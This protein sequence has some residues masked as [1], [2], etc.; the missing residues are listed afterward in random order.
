MSSSILKLDDL[1]M[2]QSNKDVTINGQRDGLEQGRGKAAVSI[3]G[4][5]TFTLTAAQ[6]RWGVLELTGVLTGNRTVEVPTGFDHS[7]VVVNNTTGAFTV[8]FKWNGG[9]ALRIPRGCAVPIRKNGGAAA[10]DE[11][12][13]A[14][15]P[16][17]IVERITSTQSVT[18][19]TDTVV[20]WNSEVSDPSESFNSSSTWDFTAP[21]PGLYEFHAQVEIEITATGAGDPTCS[22][23]LR[24]NGTVV[25]RGDRQAMRVTTAP[26]RSVGVSAMLVL[27]QGDTVDVMVRE[28]S[29]GATVRINHGS[30]KTYFQGRAIRLT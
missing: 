4:T 1:A 13:M 6:S 25:R 2:S 29:S 5:G 9:T 27:A 12:N 10:Y 16:E 26:I 7:L 19:A 20:Q 8:D 28:E 24:K 3:A 22:I 23:A 17:F 21:A 15:L 11:R 14:R 30:D 18:I